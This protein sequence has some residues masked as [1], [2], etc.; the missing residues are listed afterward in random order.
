M[1]IVFAIIHGILVVAGAYIGVDIMYKKMLPDRVDL[2]VQET[3]LRSADRENRPDNTSRMT[4]NR[5]NAI[6]SRNIFNVE[7]EA[8]KQNPAGQDSDET[9]I[10]KLEPTELKLVLWG[11]VTG[12]DPV[13]AVIEDKKKREQA[14]YEVGDRVQ[15]ATV[16]KIMRHGVV[17]HYNGK[18]QI[19]EM[20]DPTGSPSRA[21]V[22]P[23]PKSVPVPPVLNR[24]FQEGPGSDELAALM[25]EVKI[26]PH[27]S[28][29]EA[30]GLMVY[31]IRPNSVFRQIGLRNGDVIKDVNGTSIVTVE[32]AL[33]LYTEIKEADNA[34]ITLLRR[35]KEQEITYHMQDGQYVLSASS[36]QEEGSG[37]DV[38]ENE[39]ADGKDAN[40]AD[41]EREEQ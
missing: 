24:V 11:T 6:V 2:L 15:E 7:R 22:R 36:D 3:D 27:F 37:E 18:D 25:R 1:K 17:L 5:F 31:G 4:R 23:T 21:A 38:R 13:Y 20:E 41:N 35:G 40:D 10:E 34:K 30:D 33:N 16:K 28:E 39:N 9:S 19:L 12:G 8:E 26:R 29:G 32:D 14:L